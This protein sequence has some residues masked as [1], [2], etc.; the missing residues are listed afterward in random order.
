MVVVVFGPSPNFKIYPT[1]QSR[2][3]G[4]GDA[5]KHFS[6]TKKGFSVQRGEA[7]Q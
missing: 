1:T 2:F 4:L 5:T 7:I 6:V 3:L